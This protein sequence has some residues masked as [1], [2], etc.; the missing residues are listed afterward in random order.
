[1]ILIYILTPGPGPAEGPRQHALA[2]VPRHHCGQGGA[3]LGEVPWRPDRHLHLRGGHQVPRRAGRQP[4]TGRRRGL[5]AARAAT[6]AAAGRRG[7][8]GEVGAGQTRVQGAAERRP[9]QLLPQDGGEHQERDTKAAANLRGTRRGSCA[10]RSAA[11]AGT[12]STTAAGASGQM[13][14]TMHNL[15]GGAP[16]PEPD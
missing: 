2:R 11:E 15:V 9:Q 14:T 12:R 13:R 3:W 10:R 5:G 6:P 7:R 16:G 1:M 8:A 4:R